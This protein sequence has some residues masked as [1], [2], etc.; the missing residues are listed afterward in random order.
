MIF[1]FSG[2]QKASASLISQDIFWASKQPLIALAAEL[3]PSPVLQDIIS[4]RK[5]FP[6]LRVLKVF[7]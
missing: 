2:D 5:F 7:V 3:C 4:K 6:S 1:D